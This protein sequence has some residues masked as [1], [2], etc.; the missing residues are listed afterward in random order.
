[1]LLHPEIAFW[2][3]P[4]TDKVHVSATVYMTQA[5]LFEW[6][7]YSVVVHF[8]CRAVGDRAGLVASAVLI[9]NQEGVPEG[10]M[11]NRLGITAMAVGAGIHAGPIAGQ[12][13]FVS[14][15]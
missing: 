11:S 7:A 4:A 12:V 1:M 13:F 8:G 3:S 9:F 5:R 14:F 6:G 2:N 10:L 15:Y